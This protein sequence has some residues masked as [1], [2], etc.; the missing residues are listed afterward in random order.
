MRG[1]RHHHGG[2]VCDC[3][4]VVYGTFRRNIRKR[5]KRFL[6]EGFCQNY[7]Y[8]KERFTIKVGNDSFLQSQFGPE[9][10]ETIS[11]RRFLLK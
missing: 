10:S 2:D 1:K 4:F 3:V 9:A 6:R 7:S 11:Q 5:L 8:V